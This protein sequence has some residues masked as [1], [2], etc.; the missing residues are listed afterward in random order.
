MPKEVKVLTLVLGKGREGISPKEAE[1][2]L[3]ELL[4]SDWRII[5]SGG[6]TGK[7]VSDV[8]GFVILERDLQPAGR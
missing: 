5:A 8:A 2:Q 7:L 3:A 4:N 1:T 6:G